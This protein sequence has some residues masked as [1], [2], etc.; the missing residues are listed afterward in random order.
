MNN[1]FDNSVVD[2]KG[3]IDTVKL[4]PSLIRFFDKVDILRS[5]Q[6]Y[7]ELIR[8]YYLI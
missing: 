5:G 4:F 7:K 8:E 3:K 1:N 2:D 6:E